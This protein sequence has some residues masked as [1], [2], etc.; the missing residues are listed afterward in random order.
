MKTRLAIA[1]AVVPLAT[2]VSLALAGSPPITGGLVGTGV[3]THKQVAVHLSG[4]NGFVMEWARLAPGASFGWHLH[5]RPVAVVVT[6]GTLTLYDSSDPSCKASAYS[7]GQGFIEP[8]NH[9]HG[10]RNEGSKPA[11]I[12]AIYLG[13]P[14]AWRKNPTPLDRSVKSPGNCPANIR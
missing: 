10:A 11:S 9:V 8:A 5:L 3:L 12:Y 13:V 6:A 2:G 1:L 14:A 4:S 7:A